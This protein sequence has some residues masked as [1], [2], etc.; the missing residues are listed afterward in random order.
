MNRKYFDGRGVPKGARSKIRRILNIGRR[1]PPRDAG[2]VEM[3]IE[4]LSAMER[5]PRRVPLAV[6]IEC[7][8]RK[9]DLILQHKSLTRSLS[10]RRVRTFLDLLADSTGKQHRTQAMFAVWIEYCVVHRHEDDYIKILRQ[11][12]AFEKSLRAPLLRPKGLASVTAAMT[13]HLGSDLTA[14]GFECFIR[15]LS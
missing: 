14:V 10:Q 7:D 15:G 4:L 9:Q 5:L 12:K 3:Y 1:I 11:T 6:R 13:E 2:A 8:S